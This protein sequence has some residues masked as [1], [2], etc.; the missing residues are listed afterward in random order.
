MYNKGKHHGGSSHNKSGNYNGRNNTKSNEPLKPI[1]F[2]KYCRGQVWWE[3]AV[4]HIGSVQS[5]DRPVLIISDDTMNSVSSCVI[6][7]PM[8][9]KHK[10]ISESN[11]VLPFNEKSSIVLGDQPRT[12]PKENL[13]NY[14]YT[15]SPELVDQAIR[16]LL[17]SIGY[18]SRTKGIHRMHED[19]RKL[20]LDGERQSLMLALKKERD[21]IEAYIDGG[22]EHV[23]SIIGAGTS[24]AYKKLNA[25]IDVCKSCE[26]YLD[27]VLK[28]E[29][30]KANNTVRK[31]TVEESTE[32]SDIIQ[33]V[34]TEKLKSEINE[35]AS[36]NKVIEPTLFVDNTEARIKM[37]KGPDFV[38]HRTG[39]TSFEEF[40]ETVKG[41]FEKIKNGDPIYKELRESNKKSINIA[42]G[43]LI[44]KEQEQPEAV[45]KIDKTAIYS[46]TTLIKRQLLSICNRGEMTQALREFKKNG[47]FIH[48]CLRQPLEGID[49][50][51][52]LTTLYQIVDEDPKLKKDIKK[53]STSLKYKIQSLKT[54]LEEAQN[55]QMLKSAT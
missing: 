15:L 42:Y 10:F 17:V 22:I 35:I 11:V 19:E 43:E 53:I 33:P 30:K 52:Y 18:I 27:L 45:D 44:K 13:K 46:D 23:T 32:V 20:E 37:P 3:T 28:A 36:Q 1:H 7:L 16:S 31:K 50:Y 47:N 21:I 49:K 34:N 26:V 5:S 25:A 14:L 40:N 55:G 4:P 29:S 8:T 48:P 24:T 38:I 12:V 2:C 6:V 54:K 41:I 51:N 9:S 39:T